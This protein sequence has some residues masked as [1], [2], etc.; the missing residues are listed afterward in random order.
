MPYSR[1]YVASTVSRG[2]FPGLRAAMKPAPSSYASAEPKMNPRA[3]APKTSAGSRGRAQSASWRIVSAK[4]VGVGDERHEVLEDDPFRRKVRN[5]ADPVAE[6]ERHPVRSTVPRSSRTTSRCESS[7][8]TRERASRS[9]RASLRRC[10]FR[11]RR[12]GATSCST[13]AAWRPAAGHEGAQMPCVD[14]VPGETR[15]RRRD[16]GLAFA[17]ETLPSRGAGHE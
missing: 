8:A 7:C 1:S 3:S 15:A 6:I 5:V 16:V 17:V 14:A 9:S 12:P 11:A 13:S 2:S 4:Y 10:G